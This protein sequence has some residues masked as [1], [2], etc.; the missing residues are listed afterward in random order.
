MR[1]DFVR[2]P[3]RFP[4][5]RQPSSFSSVSSPNSNLFC[6]LNYE[7]PERSKGAVVW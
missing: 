4:V 2:A 7:T 5:K 1:L 3:S 6:I